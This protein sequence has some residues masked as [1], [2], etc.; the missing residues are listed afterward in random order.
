[1]EAEVEN[2]ALEAARRLT[3]QYGVGLVD[4]VETQLR[5]AAKPERFVVDPLSI[6]S[7]IVSVASLGWTIYQ[8][9]RKGGGRPS[10]ES[11]EVRVR[12][13]FGERLPFAKDEQL[14]I[15]VVVDELVHAMDNPTPG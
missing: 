13:H 10:A 15:K 6:A 3:E 5:G 1:M 12:V 11:V 7:L 8:D 9:I 2:V 14:A 4:E